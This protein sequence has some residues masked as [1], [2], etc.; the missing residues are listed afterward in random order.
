MQKLLLLLIL[1][2]FSTAGFSASCP[3]GNEPIKT[4]SADGTYFVYKCGLSV[5]E[6]PKSEFYQ[7]QYDMNS[8][9]DTILSNR[10]T[11]NPFNA[12][13]YQKALLSNTHYGIAWTNGWDK[14]RRLF[15]DSMFELESP[16]WNYY[17]PN[18][19]WSYW[20]DHA[21]QK[22][23]AT[24]IDWAHD[25]EYGVTKA[26]NV[27]HPSYPQA[28]A[29]EAVSISTKGFHGALLD[30]WHTF[31]PVP[32]KGATLQSAMENL[33]NEIR[34]QAG[35]D[36]LLIGN[37]NWR[38]NS[39][40]VSSLNGVF[41]EL[42]KTPYSRS[43]SYSFAE[44][45]EM[46]ELIKFNEEHLRYPKLI[47]LNP[48]RI[49]DKSD[50]TNRTSEDNLRFAR[51]FSAMAAVIPEHG[52]ILYGDNNPDFEEGD[53]DHYYY[54]VYSVDLGKPESKYTPI[55]QGVAYKKFEKGYIAYNRLEYD[56]TV[57]FGDFEIVIP[58]MDAVFLNYDGTSYEGCEK[59]FIKKNDIC[60]EDK[61]L[62]KENFESGARVNN[63]SNKWSI[64]MDSDGNS[65]YCNQASDDWTSFQFGNEDW[66]DYS[67]SL[68]M[69]FPSGSSNAETYIRINAKSEGYRVNINNYNG[70]TSI[71]FFPP[72]KHL[73]GSLL[74]VKRNEWMDL[75][76]IFEG[77]N[78]KFLLDDKV[79]DEI[80]DDKRKNGMAGFGASP[81]SEACVDDIVVNKI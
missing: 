10:K 29:K 78:L 35:E 30:W 53:H 27:V 56:V 18:S 49:T 64:K 6:A 12:W 5:L 55:A 69:K 61:T 80:N 54:D 75:Q 24:N 7:R 71:G 74:G 22:S 72:Y 28:F 33:S 37:T 38:K 63:W 52:Y 23:L 1:S 13:R 70:R 50:P 26:L 62:F 59:G 16:D 67:I 66:S 34:K 58:S 73:S 79:V 31:H 68:R 4:I 3:D 60:I 47:A 41:S 2:F 51:L 9:V 14:N 44:I 25:A 21:Q 36:F 81:N 43:D 17:Y 42:Y 45:A 15:S 57:N 20:N 11:I 76:L 77:N 8:E 39:R 40:L 46:E 19:P 32:W 48:W 65:I